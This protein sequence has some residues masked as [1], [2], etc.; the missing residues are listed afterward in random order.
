MKALS[1]LIRLVDS[2]DAVVALGLLSLLAAS[3]VVSAVLFISLGS[4]I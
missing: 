3:I 4:G 1:V 2:K